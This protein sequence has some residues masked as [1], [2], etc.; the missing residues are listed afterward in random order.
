MDT[1]MIVGSA[2]AV[3]GIIW[4]MWED[5][6]EGPPKDEAKPPPFLNEHQIE[7]L[8]KVS[9]T[10]LGAFGEVFGFLSGAKAKVNLETPEK[11]PLST[12]PV[13]DITATPPVVKPA[14]KPPINQT[15]DNIFSPFMSI[16]GGR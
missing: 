5:V 15:L 6:P 4:Y 16:F 8:K 14:P 1:L 12:F 9:D 13:P 10:V 3:G 7:P 11:P 2:A